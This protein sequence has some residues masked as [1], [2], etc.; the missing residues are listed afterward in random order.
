VDRE[1]AF[2]EPGD[3]DQSA[4]DQA[5]R[6]KYARYSRSYVDA[7]LSDDARAATLRLLPR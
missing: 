4:I 7:M 5:Y 6:A 1:V 2:C 3:A